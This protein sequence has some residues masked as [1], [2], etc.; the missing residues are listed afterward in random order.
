LRRISTSRKTAP[1]TNTPVVRNSYILTHGTRPAPSA[2]VTTPAPH[3]DAGRLGARQCCSLQ[4][5]AA[6]GQIPRE[7]DEGNCVRAA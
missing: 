1:A 2:R 6:L 4:G 3:R 5:L 7:G